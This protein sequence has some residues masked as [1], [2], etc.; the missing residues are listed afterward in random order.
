VGLTTLVF[1]GVLLAALGLIR[2]LKL[3]GPARF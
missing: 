2:V 3:W 1:F